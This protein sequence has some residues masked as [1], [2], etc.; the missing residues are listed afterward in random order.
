M[1]SKD[2]G[3]V[4]V[5]KVPALSGFPMGFKFFNDDHNVYI[6]PEVY[7]EIYNGKKAL[8][9]VTLAWRKESITIEEYAKR[10]VEDVMEY[11]VETGQI[12]MDE[13][14]E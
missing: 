7:A 13:I 12:I 1:L 11:G 4:K 5:T 6:S 10:L 9:Y 2:G 8:K 14:E 3:F